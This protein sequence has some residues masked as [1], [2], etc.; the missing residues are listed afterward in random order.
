M[1]FI[2]ER[3]ENIDQIPQELYPQVY[4]LER[5][6]LFLKTQ[7]QVQ[8]IKEYVHAYMNNKHV[9]AKRSKNWYKVTLWNHDR[10][11]VSNVTHYHFRQR[12]KHLEHYLNEL[13][14]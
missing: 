2:V 4:R 1:S 9:K 14:G 5:N 3:R 13:D 12:H 7:S 6:T 8:K 10:N 11:N